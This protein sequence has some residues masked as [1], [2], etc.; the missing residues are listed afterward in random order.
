MNDI[1]LVCKDCGKEFN[2]SIKEQNFYK[3]KGFANPI[4]CRECRNA[5]KT[6]YSNTDDTSSSNIFFENM[7][8]KF[9]QNTILI[10]KDK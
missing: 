5:K 4:R 3:E 7:L 2:F 9:Q 1:K 6:K 10:K 8:K